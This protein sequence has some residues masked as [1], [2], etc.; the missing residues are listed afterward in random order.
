MSLAISPRGWTLPARRKGVLLRAYRS[1]SIAQ[2]GYAKKTVTP[3]RILLVDNCTTF[4]DGFETSILRNESFQ[5]VGRAC[6]AAEVF[7]KGFLV[8][9]D[10]AVVDIDLPD[11]SGIE[12]CLRLAKLLPDLKVVLLGYHD[13]DIYLLAA[14]T[15]HAAGL[16]L[17][18][19]PVKELV[20]ALEKT[21]DGPIF[22]PGQAARIKAWKE[23]T[24]RLLRALK[25]REWQ[26]L[27]L[28]AQGQSNR[29][30]SQQLS[31]T[32]NTIEKHMSNLLE[33]LELNSRI[34]VP[35]FFYNHHLDA[36]TVL[37]HAELFMVFLTG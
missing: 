21:R 7:Q 37:P 11:Q 34:M 17:R 20:A 32:E 14:Q 23:S 3:I 26:V 13:W 35:I 30:I 8:P 24:G 29:E 9:A 31:I 1:P 27:M 33:K 25:P 18:S 16:L 2:K 12:V 4:R 5:V 19:Q 36:L 28:V 6:S 10:V 15:A 22:N